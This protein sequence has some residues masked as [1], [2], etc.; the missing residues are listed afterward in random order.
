MALRLRGPV[1]P[2]GAGHGTPSGR[3]RG[4]R[5]PRHG[6]PCPSA[7]RVPHTG[8]VTTCSVSSP[9]MNAMAMLVVSTR[10]RRSR[11]AAALHFEE[12]NTA[13]RRGSPQRPPAAP[14]PAY[15]S[16]HASTVRAKE[17]RLRD[18]GGGRTSSVSC[19]AD[20]PCRPAT[21]SGRPRPPHNMPPPASSKRAPC[22][23]PPCTGSTLA[24]AATAAK[25]YQRRI[26]RQVH[27]L[28]QEYGIGPTRAGM[29]RRI[30]ESEPVPEPA[31]HTRCEPTRLSLL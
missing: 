29:P 10:C 12:Q 2:P 23:W 7:K 18:P 5:R 27:D 24:R 17:P 26:T 25:W 22:S 31:G 8:R 3:R 30:R 13:S 14:A 19:E 11:R 15:P 20:E 4:G 16:G 9:L 6:G 21:A 28:A 1:R